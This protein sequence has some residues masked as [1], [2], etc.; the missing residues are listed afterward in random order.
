VAPVKIRVLFFASLREVMA[1]EMIEMNLTEGAT[2]ND[3]RC[4]LAQ[5]FD[6]PRVAA[7][8]ASGVRIAVNQDLVNERDL[9]LNGGDEIA[10]LPPVTG[11]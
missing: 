11:G 7:I 9:I 2:L 4:A 3:L 10:F 8:D 5:F 1:T 6:R